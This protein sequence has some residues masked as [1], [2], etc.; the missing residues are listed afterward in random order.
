MR[1]LALLLLFLLPGTALA[2]TLY[3][4]VDE[5]GEVHYS[6]TPPTKA[7]NLQEKDLRPSVIQTTGQPYATRQAVRNFP[8]TL[9]VSDCGEPCEQA[10]KHLTRR[11]IPFTTRNADDPTVQEEM[12]K[13][14][15]GLQV[16]ILLV[17]E[18]STKGYE[19]A[20]W[21]AA[22]D[23]AGYPGTTP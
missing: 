2:G 16:P 18:S 14:F 22:L 17:G 23:A 12:R 9:Y 19:P 10:K 8:V 5:K 3:K 4:W 15:G 7:K 1:P 13:R 6:D 20:T 21:D 11:A